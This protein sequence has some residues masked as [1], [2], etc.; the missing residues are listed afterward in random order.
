MDMFRLSN[1][2]FDEAKHPWL[3]LAHRAFRRMID[4]KKR[5]GWAKGALG[6][7]PTKTYRH[8]WPF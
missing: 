7:V 5:I 3:P 6:A 4:S 8:G 2:L 1:V